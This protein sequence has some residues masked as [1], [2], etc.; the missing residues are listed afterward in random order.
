MN[1]IS[2]TCSNNHPFKVP[3]KFAGKRAKCPKCGEVVTIPQVSTVNPTSQII[4]QSDDSRKRSRKRLRK[5]F[6]KT[7][8]DKPALWAQLGAIFLFCVFGFAFFWG[9]IKMLWGLAFNA[10]EI[11]VAMSIYIVIMVA[12]LFTKP[13]FSALMFVVG[14]LLSIATYF[15]PTTLSFSSSSQ[16][17]AATKDVEQIA[18]YSK[19]MT[20]GEWLAEKY[21]LEKKI[22][23]Q[24]ITVNDFY[25]AYK[26][27]KEKLLEKR[28]ELVDSVS[29]DMLGVQHDPLR[30]EFNALRLREA[31]VR[32]TYDSVDGFER[33]VEDTEQSYTGSRFTEKINRAIERYE[34]LIPI[35]EKEWHEQDAA[36][37]AMENQMVELLK[38]KPKKSW[39]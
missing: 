36:L 25:Y 21:Q 22:K 35:R 4:S 11:A 3:A 5:E 29:K 12:F 7:E 14:F 15:W 18:S 31:W 38:A 37:R 26:E 39:W 32:K 6:K 2:F 8:H 28:K 17:L 16:T 20:E 1:Q 23:N 30:R 27:S 34:K 13:Q 19:N 33:W 24:Q 10:G 9:P